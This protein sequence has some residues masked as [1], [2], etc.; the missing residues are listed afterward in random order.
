MSITHLKFIILKLAHILLQLTISLQ[1]ASLIDFSS[2]QMDQ[3]ST[4]NTIRYH[5]SIPAGNNR[6]NLTH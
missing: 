1:L 2:D 6:I 3:I 4:V 5:S